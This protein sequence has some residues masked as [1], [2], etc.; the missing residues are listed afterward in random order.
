MGK[1]V[2]A[3]KGFCCNPKNAHNSRKRVVFPITQSLVDDAKKCNI[4]LS[5]EEEICFNCRN[6][7]Y[8]LSESAD[9]NIVEQASS[10]NANLP[11]ASSSESEMEVDVEQRGFDDIGDENVEGSDLSLIHI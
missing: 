10:S 4:N 5:T 8:K 9:E 11:S 1:P 3:K 7:I 6:Y 2:A